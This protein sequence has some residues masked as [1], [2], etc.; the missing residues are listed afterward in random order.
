MTDDDQT[1]AFRLRKAPIQCT[2]LDY[3]SVKRSRLWR[4]CKANLSVLL[5][6]S[7][8]LYTPAFQ[9]VISLA[10]ATFK[11]KKKLTHALDTGLFNL[12]AINTYNKM[13]TLYS[14]LQFYTNSLCQHFRYSKINN[15][16]IHTYYL[17]GAE[18]HRRLTYCCYFCLLLQ[19]KQK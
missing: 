2:H 12:S 19:R 7:S 18:S 10:K 1:W 13:S 16:D 6:T 5:S 8:L 14:T 3:C 11:N 4:T 15:G 17:R 9:T